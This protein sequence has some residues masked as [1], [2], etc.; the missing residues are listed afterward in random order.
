MSSR[1]DLR[2]R[3]LAAVL[4]CMSSLAISTLSPPAAAAES[5]ADLAAYC[6]A[7]FGAGTEGGID[8]R[9]NGPLC[10]ERTNGGLGLL[11]HKV[12]PAEIC[13][14]QHRTSRY[15]KEGR[16]LV[17]LTGDAPPRGSKSVNLAEYCRRS[18]GETAIV[19][20]RP[21]DNRPMCT[22][23]GAGG[24]SQVHHLI[25]TGELCGGGSGAGSVR[26]DVLDCGGT[27]SAGRPGKDGADGGGAP[28]PAGEAT[29]PPGGPG[30]NGS[31][32]RTGGPGDVRVYSRAELAGLDLSDCGYA[33]LSTDMQ[34]NI[35]NSRKAMQDETGRGGFGWS[36]GGIDTPCTALGPGLAVDL[37][38]FCRW[39]HSTY[40]QPRS[41]GFTSSGRPICLGPEDNRDEAWWSGTGLQLWSACIRAYP[42]GE[43]PFRTGELSHIVKYSG[44]ALECF[45]YRQR[46]DEDAPEVFT[47]VET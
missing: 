32:G 35:A 44:G 26:G 17:C 21:A 46:P 3:C 10:T 45:Y 5:P 36:L 42:G 19:S 22:V 7:T 25:D 1:P 12:D 2:F 6:A 40:E 13:A 28:S 30:P 31:G 47:E 29:A 18:H 23:K 8:R 37:D 34:V 24:L 43:E 33:P 38:E 4:G 15:R 20:R 41:L 16:G 11:H 39:S 14:A 9:D 27:R